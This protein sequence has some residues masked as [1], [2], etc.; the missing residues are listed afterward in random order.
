MSFSSSCFWVGCSFCLRWNATYCLY[1]LHYSSSERSC[2]VWQLG[3][4]QYY[5]SFYFQILAKYLAHSWVCV[6]CSVVS[7]SLWPHGLYV[8]CQ[9]PLFMAFPRQEYWSGLLFSFSRGS[10]WPRDWT[11]VSCIAGGFFTV[12]SIR[13]AHDYH[14]LNT[15]FSQKGCYD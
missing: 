6:N 12:W 13:E 11:W 4:W 9:A 2:A 14:S 15:N 7:D 8:T 10:S 3:P 5:L 1:I